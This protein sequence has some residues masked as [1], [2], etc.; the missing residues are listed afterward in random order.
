M[1]IGVGEALLISLCGFVT[2]FLLLLFLILVIKVI[3]A[4]VMTIEGKG[5]AAAPA[6]ETAAPAPAPAKEEEKPSK[7]WDGKLQLIDVDEETAACIMAIISDETDI[8]LDELQFRRIQ[9]L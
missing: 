1:N 7:P 4:V 2:V 5:K 8:P 6:A 3:S 9:A